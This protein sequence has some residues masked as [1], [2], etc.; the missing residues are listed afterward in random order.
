MVFFNCTP[1]T[2][3]RA[4]TPKTAESLAW[5]CCAW[6]T[7]AQTLGKDT[8]KNGKRKAE[9]GKLFI[10]FRFSLVVRKRKRRQTE[11]RDCLQ[12]LP[13]CEGAKACAS[14]IKAESGKL[15]IFF[16]F[17]LYYAEVWRR[18]SPRRGVNVKKTIKKTAP[19]F[20]VRHLYYISYEPYFTIDEKK[21]GVW[22]NLMFL[23]LSGCAP[24]SA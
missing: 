24:W 23:A 18:K 9:N 20:G 13:R 3:P 16:D 19:L 4:D 1:H 14:R 12:T 2:L 7:F 21:R 5:L 10:F 17:R 8:I 6:C 22:P 11:R 15:F